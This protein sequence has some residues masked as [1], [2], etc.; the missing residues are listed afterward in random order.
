MAAFAV[1]GIVNVS[2]GKPRMVP[3]PIAAAIGNPIPSSVVVGAV[4][5]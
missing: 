1:E 3:D 4:D 5:V 2:S